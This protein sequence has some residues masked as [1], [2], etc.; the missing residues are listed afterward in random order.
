MPS[1]SDS[2]LMSEFIQR[3]PFQVDLF[4]NDTFYP[5]TKDFSSPISHP[6]WVIFYVGLLRTMIKIRNKLVPGE[7]NQ[8]GQC[9]GQIQP[10]VF[11]YL[12]GSIIDV[13]V[14]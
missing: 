7:K 2:Y 8:K 4:H 3:I 5:Y 6:R 1:F 9:L 13:Q 11:F 14:Y 12:F 10:A